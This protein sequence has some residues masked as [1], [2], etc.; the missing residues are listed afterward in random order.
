M[1]DY[2]DEYL[3]ASAFIWPIIVLINLF[4]QSTALAGLFSV[5]PIKLVFGKDAKSGIVMVTN[6]GD[7]PLQVQMKAFEWTQDAEGK[8]QYKETEEI[9]FFPKIMMLKKG[10][11]RSLRTGIKIPASVREKTYRLFIEEIPGPKKEQSGAQVQIA[12]RFGV[13][14]FVIPVKEELSGKIEDLALV[15]GVLNMVIKNT[16]NTHFIINFI[17]IKG[18]DAKGAEIFSNELSG[19]YLL[20]SVSRSY[21]TDIPQEPCQNLSKIEVEVKTDQLSLNGKLDVD[22]TMC[23]P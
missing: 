5:T 3:R 10:E 8:D 9:I 7:D 18:R 17:N 6:D 14:I 16:G 22:K 11:T 19:W 23:L 12:I 21:K 20:H 4:F 13:P 1:K 15:K 2:C